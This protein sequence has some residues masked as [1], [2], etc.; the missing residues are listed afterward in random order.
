MERIRKDRL[1]IN[2]PLYV[3]GFISAPERHLTKKPN[4]SRQLRLYV[5]SILKK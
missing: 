5:G 2:Q 1:L 3:V 4:V